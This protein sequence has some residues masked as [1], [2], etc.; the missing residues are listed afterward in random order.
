MP[1]D[2]LRRV[3]FLPTLWEPIV[4]KKGVFFLPHKPYFQK[5]IYPLGQAKNQQDDAD[6]TPAIDVFNTPQAFYIHISL[7]GAKKEDLDVSWDAENY[8]V[9][10]RGIIHRPGDEEFLK[11]IAVDERDVGLFER[12]IKLATKAEPVSVDGDGISARMED[13]ILMIKVPKIEEFIE[14]KKVDID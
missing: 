8:Q 12:K 5:L 6:F 4:K 3:E 10:V 7:P 2:R 13:G 9:I 14:I 11:T 1:E